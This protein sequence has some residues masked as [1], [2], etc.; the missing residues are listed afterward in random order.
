MGTQNFNQ[1]KTSYLGPLRS[2][3]TPLD[4]KGMGEKSPTS[5]SWGISLLNGKGL[6]EKLPLRPVLRAGTIGSQ[7]CQTSSSPTHEPG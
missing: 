3:S 1:I 6:A 2:V 7:K 4:T 5:F